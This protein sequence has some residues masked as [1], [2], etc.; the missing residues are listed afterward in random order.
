[1][2]NAPCAR[3]TQNPIPSLRSC[4]DVGVTLTVEKFGHFRLN[5]NS[6]TAKPVKKF[7]WVNK[8]GM[9]VEAINYGAT[10]ISI[11]VPDRKGDFKDVVLGPDNMEDYLNPANP[12]F[13]AT[14]GR[15][16]NR[17]GHGLMVID[18]KIHELSKNTPP[19]TLHGGFK[20]FD[21]V[22]TRFLGEL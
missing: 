19:H 5:P 17:I 16:C 1:M 4:C 10:I 22:K 15:A 11:V 13:G 20:G 6:K 8:N 14:I 2:V 12:C 18:G 9:I 3:R 21:K 7:K